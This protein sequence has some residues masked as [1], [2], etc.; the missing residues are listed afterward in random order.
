MSATVSKRRT[1]YQEHICF[2]FIKIDRIHELNKI[3]IGPHIFRISGR[4]QY[5]TYFV[6]L[7]QIHLVAEK[8]ITGTLLNIGITETEV[9]PELYKNLLIVCGFHKKL[10]KVH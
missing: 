4:S 3:S 9:N 6:Y 8:I 1:L 2:F 10:G 7:Y 5:N